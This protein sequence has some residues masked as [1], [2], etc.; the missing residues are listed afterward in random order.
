MADD[1]RVT[2]ARR[3]LACVFA[4]LWVVG[5]LLPA[6]ADAASIIVRRDPGLSAGQRAQLRADAGVRHE[7]NLALPDAELVSVPAAAQDRALAALNADPHVVYAAPNVQFHADAITDVPND[8]YFGSQWA[9]PRLDVQ[10]A[11]EG[12]EYQG[13]DG[14]GVSVAVIDQRVDIHHEDLN[15]APDA[16]HDFVADDKETPGCDSADPTGRDDHGTHVAGTIAAVRGNENGIA[17]I[18]PA[19]TVIPVR[20]LDNCGEAPLPRILAAFEYAANN[21]QIVNA[22]FSTDPLLSPDAG[23]DVG[24]AFAQ[25]FDDHPD[26]LFV[27]AAGNEGNDNDKLPVYPCST[28]LPSRVAP[29]NLVCVGMTNKDDLPVCM[30]NVGGDSVDLFAPGVEILS[31]VSGVLPYM[32]LGGTSTAAP[33][34]AAVAAL[35]K[36]L[37]PDMPPA[38][39]KYAFDFSAVDPINGIAESRSVS[40]G[41]LDAAKAVGIPR[42]PGISG[43]GG[44][45]HSCDA[46]HDGVSDVADEC[47]DAPGPAALHGCPDTDSDGLRDIEDN[48][49]KVDNPG[50]DDADGDGV[51]DAC[52]PTPR[53]NDDDHDNK[54]GADDHCPTQPAPTADGCPAVIVNPPVG[55][56]GTP[57]ITPT[58]IPTPPPVVEPAARVVSLAVKVTPRK[59]AR[60]K[61]CRKAAKVTVRVTRRATVALRVY[62]RE[63]KHG[64]GR[65]RRITKRSLLASASGKSLTVRGK[66]GRTLAK[67]RYRVTATLAGAHAARRFKV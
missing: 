35:M 23:A 53:G 9:L 34:V 61:A 41:R 8:K 40:G 62:H 3:G 60:K 19:A 46:D 55:N 5:C 63:R 48:C 18:A 45:W 59:C 12:P 15:I 52:D 50:Q 14:A 25:L 36:G 6:G 21:A 31:T 30:G 10:R 13:A 4:L 64:H 38:D 42:P 26:T 11:W 29:D 27:V 2:R 20:A 39:I 22:S 37:N 65:W 16:G 57:V 67:G 7:R 28:K 32:S 51:G 33:M 17:G 44:D 66:R 49:P 56:G 58:P 54:Y 24:R 43:P 1:T 47:D